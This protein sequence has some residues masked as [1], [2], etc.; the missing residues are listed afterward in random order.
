MD[1]K[2]VINHAFHHFFCNLERSKGWRICKVSDSLRQLIEKFDNIRLPS[3]TLKESIFSAYSSNWHDAIMTSDLIDSI[4]RQD[5][6]ISF[7]L[8]SLVV[9]STANSHCD[10]ISQIILIQK[11][12]KWTDTK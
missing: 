7:L 9:I 10:F 4:M 1:L 6:V 3:S 12:I 5:E 8:V 2:L 11:S